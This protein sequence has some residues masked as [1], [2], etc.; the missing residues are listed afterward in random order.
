MAR[1]G[2]DPARDAARRERRGIVRRQN[3][4]K[5]LRLLFVRAGPSGWA[6]TSVPPGSASR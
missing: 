3:E 6:S 1:Y 4:E 2:D 5:P